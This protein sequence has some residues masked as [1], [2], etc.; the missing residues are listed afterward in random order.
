VIGSLLVP[1]E[2]RSYLQI[3]GF[4]FVMPFSLVDRETYQRLG[5]K[6]CLHFLNILM[7]ETEDSP[8]SMITMYKSTRNHISEDRHLDTHCY[9]KLS[10]RMC[11]VTLE[12]V[13]TGVGKPGI[14][15]PWI[16]LFFEKIKIEKL[17]YNK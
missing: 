7:M 4:W 9:D 14:G 8:K 15:S 10:S 11:Y 2:S 12:W 17:I 6:F 3:N 5:G 16:F 1:K 13:S